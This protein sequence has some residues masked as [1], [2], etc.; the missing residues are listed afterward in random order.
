ME[1]CGRALRLLSRRFTR[2]E[3]DA[4]DLYQETLMLSLEKIRRREL[5][6]PERLV[7]FLRALTKNLAT[8]RY[9]RSR[10]KVE[11]PVAELSETPDR[12]Q[13]SAL[14][15]LLERERAERAR[16]LLAELDVP[17]DRAVLLRY[18]IGEEPS[19]RICA[20]LDIDTNHFY[21]VLH[22]ARQRYRRLW[23]AQARSG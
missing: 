22:R 4:D 3:A 6:E 20:D 23:E 9:R 19:R 7:P 1:R 8:Q 13:P 10:Y 16:E 14:T 12:G 5:R 15:G 11:R 2:D 18:Y 17:R 21:R